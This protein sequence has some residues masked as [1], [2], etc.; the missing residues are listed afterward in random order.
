VIAVIWH[1]APLLLMQRASAWIAYWCGYVM[2]SRILIV[3]LYN[4]TGKSV[5]AVTLFQA[6]LNLSYMLFPVYGSHFDMRLGGLITAFAAAVVI[7]L[8][9][10]GTLTGYPHTGSD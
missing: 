8:W 6:T 10:P 9:G 4:N 2:G 5:F 7:F 1:L 3:W